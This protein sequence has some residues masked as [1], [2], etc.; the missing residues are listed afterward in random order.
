MIPPKESPVPVIWK[1]KKKKKKKNPPYRRGGF[2]E[3]TK[4]PVVL[5]M[6]R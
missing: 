1:K 3:R 4:E 6:V 2:C 5:W